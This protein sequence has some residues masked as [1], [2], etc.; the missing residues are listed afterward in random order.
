MLGSILFLLSASQTN[1]SIE[2]RVETLFRALTQEEK[3]DIL[4]GTDFTTRPI[5]RLHIPPISMVD[6][7]Q[8][9]RGGTKSTQGPATAFPCGVAMSASWNRDLVKRIGKA[10]GEEALNK[11]TGAQILLGPAVNIQRSPLGGRNGEYF[12]EDPYLS[13]QLGVSYILGMQGTG[14]VACAKHY[15][16]NN[17]EVDR[18]YVNTIVS[19]R[20]LREIYLPAFE[21]SVK[22]GHVWTIMSAYNKIN[23]FH[24][25]ANK[26][27]LTDVLKKGWGF[28]GMVMSDWGAV[29]ETSRVIAAGNDLEMPG[30]GFLRGDKVALALKNGQVTQSQID[31]NVRRILRTVVRSGAMDHITKPDPSK[32][33]SPEHRRLAFEAAS[34]GIVLLKNSKE[35]LPLDRSKIRS[36]AVIGKPGNDIQIGA[37]GSPTVTPFYKV[38]PLQGIQRIVGNLVRVKYIEAAGSAD[39]IPGS[40][41][42][43]PDGQGHGLKGE[44]FNNRNLSG[45]PVAT[46]IDSSLQFDWKGGPIAGIGHDDFSVRWTGQIHP[47]VTGKYVFTVSVDDGCRLYIDDKLIVDHWV[48][49]AEVLVS[50]SVLLEGGK[51]HNMKLEYYQAKGAA[52]VRLGWNTPGQN[53][54]ADATNAAKNADVAI[55][56]AGTMGQEG[57]GNDRPSMALPGDQDSL[58]E[59]VAAANKKTIVVLNSGTPVEM[60]RWLDKTPGLLQTWFPGQEGGMALAS[61]LFGETNPSGKLPTTFGARREDYPDDGNFPGTKGK[62]NYAEGIYVGYRHFDKDKIEPFFPFGF[63]LSYTTFEYGKPTV[64]SNEGKSLRTVTL[65]VKNTGHRAG[66]EVVEVYVRPVSPSVDRPVR[67]LKG[68]E[69]VFLKPGESKSVSVSLD[70]RSFAFCDVPGQQWRADAGEYM[71]EIGASSRD[72]RQSVSTNLDKTLTQ[73]I[74][75]MA[76]SSLDGHVDK[77]N[78]AFGKVVKASTTEQRPDVSA[79]YAVDGDD[80]TRWSSSFSDP[81]WLAVDLEKPTLV[82]RVVIKWEA[83][84]ALSYSIQV[85]DDGQDWKD[86][87]SQPTSL[88]GEETIRF[89]PVSTRWVRLFAKKRATEFGISLFEFEVFGPK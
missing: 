64:V 51:A 48:D 34:E 23:G 37:N 21:A 11:G 20:A 69:K 32:V 12:S 66:A 18:D 80:Q 33:D 2:Q 14:C 4:T 78:L 5:P 71:I 68:F 82:D 52:T 39:P 59:A 49:G 84:F 72:I 17:E 89:S 30:P 22:D 3:V 58:I 61:I 74:P 67:E 15:A 41:L 55:V 47:A 73:P 63:G 50:G 65:N 44:Y 76:S 85:S 86:V 24:A 16:A 28:D 13:G 75:F 40:L 81:Q 42:T 38:Q 27:L 57:E 56:F 35:L 62:V 87:A 83:A 9:V 26:Y 31:D 79:D 77:S 60:S 19:E 10:I 46:R 43:P 45:S 8:G 6:A 54:F 25:T 88:G 1:A 36:I 53:R 29:H 7:G 70:M